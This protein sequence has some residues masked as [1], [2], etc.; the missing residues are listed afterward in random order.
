M[1]SR[2][3]ML[4]ALGREKP[5]RL[6]VTIHQ[7][8]PYHLQRYMGGVSDIEANRLCGLDA[9]INFYEVDEPASRSWRVSAEARPADGYTETRYTIETPEGTLTTAEGQSPATT[10][11]TEHLIKRDEDIE[12]MRRYRPIPRLARE[13]AVQ[14]RDALGD[15]G[16]LRTFIW[17]KQGGCWQDACELHGL[18][19]MIYATYD[20]P[21]W[22]H[23]FLKILLEQKL[24]YVE[25]SLPGT[26]FDLVET[27]GGAASNTVISADIHRDYCLPYDTALHDAIKS[28]GHRVVYH[29]CGGMTRIAGFIRQNHCDAS[30]TLSPD[31]VGGDIKTDA[32]AA[33]VYADLHPTLALIGGMDQFNTLQNGDEAEIRRQVGKLFHQYGQNGGYILSACDHFF[34]V[35]PENL[36]IFAKAAWEY[37]Y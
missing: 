2:E 27:G 33:Q 31:T 36:K 29:T 17:G 30:E 23:A 5:D 13:K 19:N 21:D 28:L 18:E 25:Q 1:T 37:T 4:R 12:L 24:K 8:Q 10:W 16:I 20:K 22:V 35:P 7:W 26:P 11:V 3:R 14:V 34:D 15:G 32:D 6:P 9:S